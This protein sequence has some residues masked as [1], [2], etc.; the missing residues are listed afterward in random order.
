MRIWKKEI[1]VEQLT[2]THAD[3]VVSLLGIE[4][5]EVG[6]DSIRARVPVDRRTVQVGPRG[7]TVVVRSLAPG[8]Y[9][10][11][12]GPT[13]TGPVRSGVAVVPAPWRRSKAQEPGADNFRKSQLTILSGTTRSQAWR[14][15]WKTWPPAYLS[16]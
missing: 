15:S 5:L 12:V 2:L 4:F 13:R 16:A 3:T 7:V 6:D 8:R 1:S 9:R 11:S 14:P 10:W